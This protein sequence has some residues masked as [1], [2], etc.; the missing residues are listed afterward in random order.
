MFGIKALYFCAWGENIYFIN[1]IKVLFTSLVSRG[2][3]LSKGMGMSRGLGMSR[4]MILSKGTG[5]SRG[6]GMFVHYIFFA[7]QERKYI[8][9]ELQNPITTG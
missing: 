9:K 7:S 6:L 2:M 8:S 4:G 1:E 3:I 5:M